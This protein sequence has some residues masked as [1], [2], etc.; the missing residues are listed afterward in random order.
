Q[1]DNNNF[2]GFYD[3]DEHSYIGAMNPLEPGLATCLEITVKVNQNTPGTIINNSVAIVSDETPPAMTSVDVEVIP[4]LR[5]EDLIIT[6]NVLRRNGTSKYITAVVQ[7]P[8]GI[9]QSDIDRDNRP[10]LYYQDR[11]TDEF[12]LIGTGSR[13]DLSGTEISISFNRA[14]LMD[15]LYGYGEFNLKVMGQLKS[16]LTFYGYDIIHVTKFAGD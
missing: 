3:P 6:P 1:D 16:G 12:I 11:N 7:F 13:P 8:A 4:P 15:A 10:A 2:I 9:K 14:E 5:V